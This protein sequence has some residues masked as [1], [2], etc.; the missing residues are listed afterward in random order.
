MLERVRAKPGAND[1]AVA[2]RR[3]AQQAVTAARETRLA[4][5]EAAKIAEQACEAAEREARQTAEKE[6]RLAQEATEALERT[7]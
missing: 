4:E 7:E 3:A 2:E 5:R 6:Q 1:P